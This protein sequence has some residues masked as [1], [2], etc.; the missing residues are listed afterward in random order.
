MRNIS[1]ATKSNNAYQK[2]KKKYQ[3]RGGKHE[4]SLIIESRDIGENSKISLSRI[5]ISAA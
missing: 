4:N 3:R 1:R 2:K 5:G